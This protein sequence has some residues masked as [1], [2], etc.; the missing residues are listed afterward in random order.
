MMETRAISRSAL[1]N[2]V[3]QASVDAA[4]IELLSSMDDDYL[5][6]CGLYNSRP[7]VGV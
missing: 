5:C 3:E 6:G 4:V 7:E 2:G 1:S